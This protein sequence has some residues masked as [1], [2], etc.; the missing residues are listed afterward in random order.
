MEKDETTTAHL[1]WRLGVPS[2]HFISFND[3]AAPPQYNRSTSCGRNHAEPFAGR[4]ATPG[5]VQLVRRRATA[6]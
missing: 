5:A 4:E 6:K 2:V 1:V 3:I